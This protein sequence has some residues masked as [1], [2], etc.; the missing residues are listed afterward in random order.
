[1]AVGTVRDIEAERRGIDETVDGWTVCSVFDAVVERFPDHPLI[2]WRDEDGWNPITASDYRDAVREVTLGL[3]ESGFTPGEF[4]IIQGANRPEHVITDLGIVHAAGASVSAYNTLSPDQLRY[5]AGHCE[6]TVVIVEDETYLERWRQIRGDLPALR[7][8]VL[9]EGEADDDW[10]ITW[11]ELRARGRAAHDADPQRFERT[12]RQ[13]APDDV[14]SVIYTSG[15]TGQP[16]GV[17]YTHRNI[18]WTAE[19]ERLLLGDEI[20][21]GARFISYLPLA[22]IAERFQSHW[23]PL[24]YTLQIGEPG[25]VR[26]CPDLTQILLY[27]IETRPT[28]FVGVPRIWEKFAAAIQAGIAAEQDQER[29]QMV[30]RAIAVGRKRAEL[31]HAGQDVPDEV[32]EGFERSAPVYQAIKQKLGLDAC[33]F[34]VTTTAPIPLDLELFWM[35]LDLPLVQVWGMSELTGPATTVPLDD[36]RPGTVGPTIP[37]VEA[38]LDEDGELLIRGGNV[39]EGYYRDPERTA[40]TVDEDGWLR[41]GDIAEVDDR[42]WYRI[43]DRKKELIITSSGK[44]ISPSNVEALLKMDPLVGQAIAVGDNRNYL[45]ALIVLDAEVA[46]GWAAQHGIEDTSIGGLSDHPDVVAEVRRGIEDANAQL[47]RIEQIKRFTI[48]P[49]EWTAESGELTPTQKMKRRVV[50]DR[51]A[52]AIDGMYDADSPTGHEVVP[53]EP[54]TT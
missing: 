6:A 23:A 36:V 11:D 8:A 29:K 26:Y 54:A 13:V 18:V 43:V 30:E 42:G 4:A 1:M 15:T 7:L 34:A 50:H 49:D 17:T 12:W 45:T 20:L 19:S 35:A 53:K 27:L 32:A 46:P 44:N 22:H 21:T 38:E 25:T 51:Y 24:W 48:L 2:E 40:E 31:I 37:G 33:D 14:I 9:W 41:T 47:A 39:M 52:D 5:L 16:K 28:A 3:L 10:V